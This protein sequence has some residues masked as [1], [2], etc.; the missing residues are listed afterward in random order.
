MNCKWGDKQMERQHSN[1]I[2]LHFFLE[3]AN[4]DLHLKQ[5]KEMETPAGRN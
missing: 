1:L 3:Q 2:S 5:I 4:S